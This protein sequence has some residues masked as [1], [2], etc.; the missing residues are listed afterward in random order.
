MVLARWQQTVKILILSTTDFP[1]F[2]ALFLRY[3]LFFLHRFCSGLTGAPG[4]ML[5]YG[6]GYIHS[7]KGVAHNSDALWDAIPADTVSALIVTAAAAAAA[8][9]PGDGSAKV[10][11]AASA[12]SHPCSIRQVYQAAATFWEANPCPSKVPFARSVVVV[13]L[14]LLLLLLASAGKP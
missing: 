13:L 5:G 1:A 9:G 6:T 7:I 4:F 12:D 2:P 11:H 10:Y 14:L 8:N 3:R